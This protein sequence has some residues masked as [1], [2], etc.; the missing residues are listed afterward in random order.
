MADG[1]AFYELMKKSGNDN[2]N[3]DLHV[4]STQDIVEPSGVALDSKDQKDEKQDRTQ[5]GSSASY[6]TPAVM[7]ERLS[8]L[9][10]LLKRKKTLWG[11]KVFGVHML[12]QGSGWLDPFLVVV[13]WYILV[14]SSNFIN[15][16]WVSWWTA[17]APQ[18]RA[19]T[20]EFYVIGYAVVAIA[21][22]ILT[23][24]RTVLITI[25]VSVLQNNAHEAL[26]SVLAAQCLFDQTPIGRIISRF[27][28]DIHSMDTELIQFMDFVF[29]C[30]LYIIAMRDNVRNALVCCGNPFSAGYILLYIV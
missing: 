10:S 14:V 3:K 9:K 12:Y 28:G 30:G 1:K 11:S 24:C 26:D 2:K 18:Y 5:P 6:D 16:I 25:L 13:L 20:V 22:A 8:G 7:E 15:T 23:F 17:D 19:N 29:W 21:V 4:S 27:S